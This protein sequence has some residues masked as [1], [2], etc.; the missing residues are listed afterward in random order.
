LSFDAINDINGNP[1]SIKNTEDIVLEIE[2]DIV[3]ILGGMDLVGYI[4]ES[5]LEL[6]L[7]FEGFLLGLRSIFEFFD[8]G[9]IKIE[10][11]LI[12]SYIFY[13]NS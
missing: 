2:E 10:P 8:G 6:E 4:V 3:C 7:I 9:H 13:R 1:F 5:F 11:F 12:L